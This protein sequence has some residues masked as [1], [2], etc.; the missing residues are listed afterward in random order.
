MERDD[1]RQY[2]I[3]WDNRFPIDRWWRKKYNI[4]FNSSAHRESSFLDQLVEWEEDQLFDEIMNQ[5]EY[6]P[7]TGDFL[8][9]KPITK[10][11]IS[12]S[13]SSSRDEFKALTDDE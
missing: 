9:R 2:I 11:N 4:A 3:E 1:I 13:I 7:N 5:E 10:D 12:Q 8:K 6:I